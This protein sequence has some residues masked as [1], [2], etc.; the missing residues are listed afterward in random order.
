MKTL[1]VPLLVLCAFLSGCESMSNDV[2]EKFAGAEPKVRRFDA[3]PRAVYAAAKAALD[4][5]SF[6][7]ISGGAAQG[8]LEAVS[9]L[10]S[11][12]D[13]EGTRQVSISIRIEQLP[14]GSSEVRAVLKEIVEADFEKGLATQT[15][16]RDTPYYEVFFRNLANA[17]GK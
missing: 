13:R 4:R 7:V 10:S 6:R 5:M 14:D 9:G 2:R 11:D 3:E 17:L 1:L 8:K 15:A 12:T 16:L